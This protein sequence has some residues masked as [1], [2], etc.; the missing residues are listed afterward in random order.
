MTINSEFSFSIDLNTGM[1][2]KDIQSRT[3]KSYVDEIGM[4]L[5]I[6]INEFNRKYIEVNSLK[7]I[8]PEREKLW[9]TQGLLNAFDNGENN[10]EVEFY[11]PASDRYLK[12]NTLMSRDELQVM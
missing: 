11:L 8:D 9:F 12:T 10:I 1:L 6:N 2:T 3:G 5:P 4:E 7:F